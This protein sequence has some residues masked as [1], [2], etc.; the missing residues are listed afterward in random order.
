L[1]CTGAAGTE[2]D[3]PG[4]GLRASWPP[5]FATAGCSAAVALTRRPVWSRSSLERGAHL[6]R[7][8]QVKR[9]LFHLPRAELSGSLLVCA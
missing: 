7:A 5:R 6:G 1:P 8:H 4:G 9:V 3:S 2:P